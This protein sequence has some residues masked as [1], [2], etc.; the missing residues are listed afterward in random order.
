MDELLKE[1]GID[2]ATFDT[3]VASA[4]KTLEGTA[5]ATA[6]PAPAETKEVDQDVAKAMEMLKKLGVAMK[7]PTKLQAVSPAGALTREKEFPGLGASIHTKQ[8]T[9]DDLKN[10][11]IARAAQYVLFGDVPTKG[12]EIG[13]ELERDVIKG[14]SPDETRIKD[15]NISTQIAGGFLVPTITLNELI[16]QWSAQTVMR[17]MG[18]QIIPNAGKQ[19]QVPK[20]TGNTTAYWVGDAPTSDITASAVTFGEMTLTLRPLAAAVEIRKNLIE[21]AAQSVEQIVRTDIIEQMALAEDLA[22]LQGSG[23]LQ[24]TGLKLWP[25][26]SSY[27][28]GT[29]GTPDFDELLDC[30]GALLARN[31]PVS[32]VNSCWIM[33]PNVLTYIQKHKTG[34]GTYDYVIDLTMTPPDRVLGLPV[35]TSSQIPIT[36][37]SPAVETYMVLAG[38]R[39]DY[40]IADGPGLEILVDPYTLSRK[41]QVQLIAVHEVDGG[42]RRVESFQFLTGVKTA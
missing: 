28:T 20:K 35:F 19:I 5:T 42:P 25:G 23:G 6:D 41:L 4:Q 7:D 27:T 8:W 22:F 34:V 38:Y 2:K 11:S 12:S 30:R 31:I 37:G 13:N 26:M 39:P 9:Q 33:H 10:F 24:P 29:V 1:L 3:I 18:A 32:A 16:G 15:M 40:V 14:Y 36:L 21:H 17:R